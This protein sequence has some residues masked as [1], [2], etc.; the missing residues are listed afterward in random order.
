VVDFVSLDF[1]LIIKF[2][3]GE[4]SSGLL[5]LSYIDTSH[6]VMEL[7]VRLIFFF[8]SATVLVYLGPM[9]KDRTASPFQLKILTVLIVL[10]VIASNPLIVLSYFTDSVILPLA[11]AASGLALVI[12][13]AAGVLLISEAS[14]TRA[15][16]RAAPDWIWVTSAPFLAAGGL[17]FLNS[18]LSQLYGFSAATTG[19]MGVLGYVRSGTAAICF[20]RLVVSLVAFKSEVGL[21]RTV[22]ATIAAVTFL[23]GMISE[24]FLVAEPLIASSHEVQIFTFASAATLVLFLTKLYWPVDAAQLVDP[25][26]GDEQV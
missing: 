21:E 18:F 13:A 10:I 14:H 6:A 24:L 9:R 1:E 22:M 19:F 25:D 17:Y 12:G 5:F 7:L 20:L 4:S 2:A 11:D 8:I 23:V 15:A 16:A 3:E 26:I